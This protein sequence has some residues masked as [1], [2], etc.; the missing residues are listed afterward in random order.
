MRY[1]RVLVHE[2][3]RVVDLVVDHHVEILLRRVLADIRIRELLRFGHGRWRLCSWM[4]LGVVFGC[5]RLSEAVEQQ[6]IEKWCI[7]V[8]SGE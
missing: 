7:D 1:V 2:A 6:Q 8:R 3:R 4:L 5:L